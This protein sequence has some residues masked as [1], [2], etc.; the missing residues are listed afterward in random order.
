M[1]TVMWWL[2]IATRRCRWQVTIATMMILRVAIVTM[3]WC[4]WTRWLKVSITTG[5]PW[6]LLT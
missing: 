3:R 1:A 5:K 6:L 4:I 2:Y